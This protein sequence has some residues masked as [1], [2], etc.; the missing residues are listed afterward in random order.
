MQGIEIVVVLPAREVSIVALE[1]GH[2]SGN[3]Q[4]RRSFIA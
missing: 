2:R 4:Q 3:A 1:M